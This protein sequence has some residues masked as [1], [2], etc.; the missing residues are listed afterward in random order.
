[1]EQLF[2]QLNIEVLWKI[3]SESFENDL[4][5]PYRTA[6]LS[7]SNGK[8]LGKFGQIHP[9]YADTNGLSFETYLFEL[10]FKA[11]QDQIQ[12]NKLPIFQ[13]YPVYPKIIKDLS[14]IIPKDI[15]FTELKNLLYLNGT[16]FLSEINLLDEY[17]GSSIPT[18]C[19]SLCVQLVFQSN[20]KT[21]EN[22]EIE[23]IL[24]NLQSVLTTKFNAI[25]RK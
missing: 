8:D 20:E 18:E 22:K 10:N 6:E 7:L 4:F 15:T 24:N 12:E 11:L 3:E 1:M 13:E 21:L 14:F 9:V 2:N 16:K 25:I 5:H 17:R 23:S 19:T